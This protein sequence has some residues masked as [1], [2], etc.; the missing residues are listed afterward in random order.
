MLVNEQT[1]LQCRVGGNAAINQEALDD[2]MRA[3][4]EVDCD[5][6][7]T[8]WCNNA[9]VKPYVMCSANR[10]E[11]WS[12]QDP[13]GLAEQLDRSCTEDSDC[14]PIQSSDPEFCTRGTCECPDLA[15]NEAAWTKTL[16]ASCD[17]SPDDTCS[18][19]ACPQG[20]RAVCEQNTCTLVP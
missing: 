1:C 11:V 18:P 10:C 17:G 3:Q 15:V 13:Q 20:R 14:A 2:F 4:D 9:T 5:E 6:L 7:S 8:D 12:P 16:N 19:D